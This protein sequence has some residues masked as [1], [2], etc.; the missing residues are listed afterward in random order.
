MGTHPIFE[1]DFDCLTEQKMMSQHS[2]PK[3]WRRDECLRDGIGANLV[4]VVYW[5]P[6]GKKCTTK[7]E[8]M[9]E[10]GKEWDAPECLDFKT[11]VYSTDALK[12]KQEKEKKKNEFYLKHGHAPID[13][14]FDL[15][16]R[17]AQWCG[18]MP[19]TLVRS[20]PNNEIRHDQSKEA[21]DETRPIAPVRQRPCQ[22]LAEKRFEHVPSE[23]SI[24]QVTP[25]CP[26]VYSNGALLTRVCSQLNKHGKLPMTGQKEKPADTTED[27]NLYREIMTQDPVQPLCNPIN[28]TET[29]IIEQENKVHLAQRALARAM[30]LFEMQERERRDGVMMMT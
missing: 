29:E 10:L 20:F 28:V 1:S 6:Q 17:R 12:K 14:N 9:D 22:L 13:Y 30:K 11:G 21:K 19:L 25:T 4:Q 15:P 16:V 24:K 5:S 3:G 8:L 23:I 7:R 26:Q 18:D 2:L 27:T